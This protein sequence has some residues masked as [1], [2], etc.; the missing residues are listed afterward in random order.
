MF[1][2][3]CEKTYNYVTNPNEHQELV[4]EFFGMLTRYMRYKPSAVIDST[5]LLINLKFAALTIGMEHFGAAKT[6]YSFIEMIFKCCSPKKID[7][8]FADV[9]IVFLFRNH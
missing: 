5:S 9:I 2:F 8:H 1:D 6:T 4:E 3:M 7:K